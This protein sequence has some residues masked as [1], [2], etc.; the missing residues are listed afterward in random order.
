MGGRPVVDGSVASYYGKKK[1]F[2]RRRVDRHGAV[3]A[4]VVRE[5]TGSTEEEVHGH[6][7]LKSYGH[8]EML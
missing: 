4:R 3:Y 5:A 1:T 7:Q 6:A 2:T 8:P